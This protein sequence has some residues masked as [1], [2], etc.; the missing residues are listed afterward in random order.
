MKLK[1]HYSVQSG[2]DGSAYPEFMESE[3]LANWDQS[4][5]SEGWGEPCTGS[6]EIES[7]SPMTCEVTTALGYYLAKDDMDYWESEGDKE[8][9]MA[10]FFP[11]GLPHMDVTIKNDCY[12]NVSVDEIV[13]YVAFAYIPDAESQ[14]T[15]EGRIALEKELNKFPE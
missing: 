2:G 11:D 1:I 14:T 12:Y 13:Q 4:H 10:A 15:E 3:K 8:E 9:F 7:E 6:L 5:M